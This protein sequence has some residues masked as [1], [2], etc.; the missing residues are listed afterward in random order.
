VLQVPKKVLN[1]KR[2]QGTA[3]IHVLQVTKKGFEFKTGPGHSPHPCVTS[4][5]K[6]F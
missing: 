1:L 6:R 3:L 5:K 2:V 4:T